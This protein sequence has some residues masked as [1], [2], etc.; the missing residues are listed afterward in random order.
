MRDNVTDNLELWFNFVDNIIDIEAKKVIYCLNKT[1]LM[2]ENEKKI[3]VNELKALNRQKKHHATI[4]CVSSKNSDGI[5]NL[6][7]LLEEKSQEKVS[8]DLKKFKYTINIVLIGKAG[9]GKSSLIERIINNSFKNHITSTLGSHSNFIKVDLKN[10]SSINYNYIDTAG[11]EKYIE[12][13]IHLLDKAH[14]IIFVNDK[15]K[16]D[17]NTYLIEGRVLLSDVKIICCIN[18]KDQFSDVENAEIIKIFKEKNEKLKDKPII[19]VSAKTSDGIEELK[20]KINEYSSNIVDKKINEI[21][22][23]N[24]SVDLNSKLIKKEKKKCCS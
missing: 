6:E 12:T 5:I 8:N 19:L 20:N 11:Q 22:N 17:V 1:D 16:L 3:I 21:Q 23:E 24:T 10:H 14:I 13:W 7:N 2:S 9:V 15:D 18:K 4:E